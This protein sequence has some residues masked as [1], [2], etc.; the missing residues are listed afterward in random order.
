MVSIYVY[1][2]IYFCKH[3]SLYK[4]L[5]IHLNICICEYIFTHNI[6]T[7]KYIRQT[8]TD[9]ERKIDS[10]EKKVGNVSTL[11]NYNDCL[12]K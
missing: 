6:E 12:S 8:L 3:I 7:P 1:R 9:I 2:E 11:P 10:K 4:Y 5:Y